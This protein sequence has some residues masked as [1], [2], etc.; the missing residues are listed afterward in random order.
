VAAVTRSAVAVEE[1]VGLGCT[2]CH[3]GVEVVTFIKGVWPCGPW[4]WGKLTSS[5]YGP[6]GLLA[7]PGGA[8]PTPPDLGE[9]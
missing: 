7:Q 2:V 4:T 5:L 8:V 6:H 1:R 9:A 3:A